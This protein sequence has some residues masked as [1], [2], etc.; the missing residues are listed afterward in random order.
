MSRLVPVKLVRRFTIRI[1]ELD[2]S[3]MSAIMDLQCPPKVH[4]LK[5]HGPIGPQPMALLGCNGIFKK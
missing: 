3:Y 1:P 5:A 4:V 2:F